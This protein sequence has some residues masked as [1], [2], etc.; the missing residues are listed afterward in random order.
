GVTVG[1]GGRK[2]GHC[3]L[4]KDSR[5]ALL[6][7]PEGPEPVFPHPGVPSKRQLRHGLRG[8]DVHGAVPGF[9]PLSAAEDA[10]YQRHAQIHGTS[11]LY[12][13]LFSW[14]HGVV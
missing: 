3:R 11:W 4:W 2:L 14:E 7:C 8:D 10:L 9:G 1:V 12:D 6:G 13:L 5:D